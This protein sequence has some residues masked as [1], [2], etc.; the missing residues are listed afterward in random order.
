MAGE[1]SE[2]EWVSSHLTPREG[3]RESQSKIFSKAVFSKVSEY[4]R[5]LKWL[6]GFLD[7]C[8]WWDF[9]GCYSLMTGFRSMLKHNLWEITPG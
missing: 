7:D 4:F 1:T 3:G 8:E 5:F 9:R 2:R 6:I